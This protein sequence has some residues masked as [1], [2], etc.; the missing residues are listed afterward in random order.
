MTFPTDLL[1]AQAFL[2]SRIQ[3]VTRVEALRTVDALGCILAEDIFAPSSLP[4]FANAAMDGYAVRGSDLSGSVTELKVGRAVAAGDTTDHMLVAGVAM[5]ITTGAIIPPGAT[6]VV[7]Y[8]DARLEGDKVFLSPPDGGRPHIR[9]VGEDIS[10]GQLALSRGTLLRPGHMPL[11][12]ALGI[13]LVHV[14]ARPRVAI[15]STG[16]EL[17]EHPHL[18]QP[19]QIHDTNRPMITRMLTDEGATV[20]D[21]GISTDS[22]DAIT[23]ALSAA[24]MNHDLLVTTGGASMSFSDHVARA[25]KTI[26]SIDFWRLDMRPGK[27]V[28]FGEIGACP[29][30]IL[31]GNPVAAASGFANLGRVVLQKLAGTNNPQTVLRLPITATYGKPDGK[32]HMLLSRI[33]QSSAGALGVEPL[34]VQSSSSYSALAAADVLIAVRPGQTSLAPGDLVDV[35]PLWGGGMSRMIRRSIA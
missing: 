28:G 5:P 10:E 14:I 18:P 17:I 8:E 9:H 22:P 32:T 6:R 21:L 1:Q 34:P 35:V 13:D 3:T 33:V 11:L 15:L 20:T 31:P 16:N 23:Q 27:P 12:I 2:T 4:R 30:L 25:V 29:I 24:S 26:G 19:G 7:M